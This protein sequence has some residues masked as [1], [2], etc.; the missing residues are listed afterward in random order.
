MNRSE[1]NEAEAFRQ[2]ILP[3]LEHL[4]RLEAYFRLN[5]LTSLSEAMD[6][7]LGVADDMMQRSGGDKGTALTPSSGGEPEGGNADAPT[8]DAVDRSRCSAGSMQ[9]KRGRAALG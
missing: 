7:V 2:V 1:T 8:P 6:E 9:E 5:G 4:V 3:A